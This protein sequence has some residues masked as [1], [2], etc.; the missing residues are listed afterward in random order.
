MVA[1]VFP[2]IALLLECLDQGVET[3]RHDAH[4][5]MQILLQL[6]FNPVQLVLQLSDLLVQC[7]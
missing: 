3:L 1:G 5:L 2:D 7:P 6:I 4:L